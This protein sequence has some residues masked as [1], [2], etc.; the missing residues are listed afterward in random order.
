MLTILFGDTGFGSVSSGTVSAQIGGTTFD[1][2]TQ[3]GSSPVTSTGEVSYLTFMDS[4]NTP[5]ETTTFLTTQGPLSGTF[6]DNASGNATFGPNTSLT[7]EI[8]IAQGPD[9]IT[10]F[11]STLRITSALVA[12]DNGSAITLFAAALLALEGCRRRLRTAS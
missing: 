2:A 7:Q 12:P 3:P 9:A 8:I 5:L 1:F 6:L 4:G 11:R 10:E